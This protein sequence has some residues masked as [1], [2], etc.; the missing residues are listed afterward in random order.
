MVESRFFSFSCLRCTMWQKPSP[1][2]QP[3]R[4]RAAWV[5]LLSQALVG[6]RLNLWFVILS[7]GLFL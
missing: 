6:I 2:A 5:D 3:A 4:G 7:T 1:R